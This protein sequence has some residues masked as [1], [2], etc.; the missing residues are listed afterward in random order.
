MNKMEKELAFYEAC[1]KHYR[2]RVTELK[3]EI[4]ERK[5]HGR[6][7]GQKRESQSASKQLEKEHFHFNSS[8]PGMVRIGSPFGHDL[9]QVRILSLRLH[10]EVVDEL[11]Q[12]FAFEAGD[13][14]CVR[15]SMGGNVEIKALVYDDNE[16]IQALTLQRWDNRGKSPVKEAITLRGNDLT[17]FM[18]FIVSSFYSEFQEG[19][20]GRVMI[21]KLK[22]SLDD[23]AKG[24]AYSRVSRIEALK[25][26]LQQEEDY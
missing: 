5:A 24:H 10:T 21:D 1:L 17:R 6:S 23:I 4:K 11:M 2:A 12:V 19:S 9:E 7:N 8:C 14:Q 26:K 15:R 13:V 25:W 18:I 16:G 3:N 22:Q 20:G